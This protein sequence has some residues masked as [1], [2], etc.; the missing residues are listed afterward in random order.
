MVKFKINVDKN[1][2]FCR[3]RE[4]V[5]CI[6]YTEILLLYFTIDFLQVLGGILPYYLNFLSIV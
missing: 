1:K 3:Y 4:I 6:Q 2:Y 5:Y